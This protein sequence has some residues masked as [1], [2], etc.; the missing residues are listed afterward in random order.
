MCD[1]HECLLRDGLRLAS[2][3]MLGC[4]DL[5]V[6]GVEKFVDVPLGNSPSLAF[7]VRFDE[8]HHAPIWRESIIFV[9]CSMIMAW[10]IFL[11][12]TFGFRKL[13][14]NRLHS[15]KTAMLTSTPSNPVKPASQ[16]LNCCQHHKMPAHMFFCAGQDCATFT[17]KTK[18]IQSIFPFRHRSGRVLTIKTNIRLLTFMIQQ[19]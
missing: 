14:L 9:G 16:G 3:P 7:N 2:W 6:M 10:I 15:P 11:A 17:G 4:D 18:A 1:R 12:L 19:Q 8:V 5:K 13:V